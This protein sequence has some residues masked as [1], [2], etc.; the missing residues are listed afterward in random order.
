MTSTSTTEGAGDTVPELW[1]V[2]PMEARYDE[3]LWW[4]ASEVVNIDDMKPDN[5][6]GN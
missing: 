2:S 6:E 3:N 1:A 4:R 5:R